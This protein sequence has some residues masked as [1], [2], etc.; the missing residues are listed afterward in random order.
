M[1]RTASKPSIVKPT[2]DADTVHAFAEGSRREAGKQPVPQ[3]DVR[4]N[5]NVRREL[6]TRIKIEAA[7]QGK[8][9]GELIEQLIDKHIPR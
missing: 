9:I 1:T 6:H 8:S 3:G 7:R 4:L 2:I 5:A